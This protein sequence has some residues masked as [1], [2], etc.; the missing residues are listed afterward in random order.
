MLGDVAVYWFHRACH[1]V[2]FLWRFHAVHHSVETLDWVAAH[3]EH[4]LDGLLTQWAVN[5]PL[6][7]LGPPIEGLAALATFRG[8]WALVIHANVKIPLGPLAWLLGSP[9]LHH[10]HHAKDA[11]PVANF[12]NVAPW[13]DVVF[14]T[15]FRPSDERE[16]ELGLPGFKARSWLGHVLTPRQP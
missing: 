14:G 10:W 11:Q 13:T 16:F 12:G 4:P 9:Q 15:H 2:P 6:L 7:L 8:L 3:R 5:V 1:A